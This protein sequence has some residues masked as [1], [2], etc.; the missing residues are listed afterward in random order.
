[1]FFFSVLHNIIFVI[2][3]NVQH[4]CN[5]WYL[6]R[7]YVLECY[8]YEYNISIKR[9]IGNY[10]L[11]LFEITLISYWPEWTE[12][13]NQSSSMLQLIHISQRDNSVNRLKVQKPLQPLED[14]AGLFDCS[15]LGVFTTVH[16]CRNQYPL[17]MVIEIRSLV[18]CHFLLVGTWIWNWVLTMQ[19]HI[20]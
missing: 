8:H 3:M 17:N 14:D 20:W 12:C 18:H 6:A 5:F 13:G 16:W 9:H 15:N 4:I 1:M 2:Y 19:G 7:V 10:I 11:V